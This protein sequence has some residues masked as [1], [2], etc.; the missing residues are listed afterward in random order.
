M[1]NTT[2]GRGYGVTLVNIPMLLVMYRYWYRWQVEKNPDEVEDT[3]RF[4]G[5]FVLP[6]MVDSYLDISFF[7][8]VD[9]YKL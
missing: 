2:Q 7:K 6:N 3:Y 5:S 1:N 8:C 4:I 9:K